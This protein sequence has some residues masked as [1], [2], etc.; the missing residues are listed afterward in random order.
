MENVRLDVVNKKR[1][2]QPD[3]LTEFEEEIINITRSLT[4]V[5]SKFIAHN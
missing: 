4:D 5:R 2:Q 3:K 1:V